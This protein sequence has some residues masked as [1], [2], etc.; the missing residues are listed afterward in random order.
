[1]RWSTRRPEA[2][3]RWRTRRATCWPGGARRRREC[4][5]P[6]RPAPSRCAGRRRSS[7]SR[8]GGSPG[9][10]RSPESCAWGGFCPFSLPISPARSVSAG[11]RLCGRPRRPPQA[12]RSCCRT[13]PR[14]RSSSA[15]LSGPGP[16]TGTRARALTLAAILLLCLPLLAFR[17][18]WIG[19]GL[20]IA[21]VSAAAWIHPH[22]RFLASPHAWICALG[23]LTLPWGLSLLRERERRRQGH[24]SADR[25]RASRRRDRRGPRRHG[26]GARIRLCAGERRILRARWA[27][28][29]LRRGGRDRRLRWSAPRPAR[30]D[31]RGD[32]RDRVLLRAG[33]GA[34]FGVAGVSRLRVR[35]GRGGLRALAALDLGFVGPEG[36]ARPLPTDRGRGAA[37]RAGRRPELR[38]RP[39][40][41]GLSDGL[42]HPPPGP[43]ADDR[44]SGGGRAESG[45]PGGAL[46]SGP[47]TA[48]AATRRG[49]LG[50]RVPVVAGR[51]GAGAVFD[52]HRLRGVRRF[53]PAAQPLLADSRGGPGRVRRR[54]RGPD[55]ASS[56]RR[57]AAARLS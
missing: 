33:P 28:G 26:A 48:R 54:G 36:T 49:P 35:R 47:G 42:G 38:A 15:R 34:R 23:P 8:A 51:R 57:G 37:A 17:P 55:R 44:G 20:A 31:R 1:M 7:S 32:L 18:P 21:L 41:G 16:P 45:R 14:S 39:R 43:A 40:G 52:A 12:C 30:C 19:A 25:L 56:R 29:P 11:R 46:R 53:R 3:S 2:G 13:P 10:R 6:R 22:G 27:H 4:R 5:R 24:A 50:P 9:A